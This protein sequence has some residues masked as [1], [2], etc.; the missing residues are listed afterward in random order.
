MN[1]NNRVVGLRLVRDVLCLFGLLFGAASQCL[2]V[3]SPIQIGSDPRIVAY[4]YDA[5]DIF[6]IQAR[7]MAVTHIQLNPDEEVLSFALG[8]TVQ[9]MTDQAGSNIFIKPI[10]A[11][12]STNAILT[13][14]KRTYQLFLQ[15]VPETGKWYQSVS[16]SY[17]DI[18]IKNK[19]QD[20][21]GLSRT[22]R[23]RDTSARALPVSDIGDLGFG[24]SSPL[25]R[26]ST[27]T[28]HVAIE[29]LNFDYDIEGTANFKPLQVFDDGRHTW[30]HM[31]RTAQE[32]PALFVVAE[33]GDIQLANFVVKGEYMVIQRLFPKALLKIGKQEV[34][35]INRKMKPNRTSCIFCNDN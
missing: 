14:S 10:R 18:L 29:N 6:P 33:D 15:S 5:K 2:A 22:S 24:G 17:P 8:D 34:S 30:L 4:S 27:V 12:L 3:P 9:W 1:S 28:P 7:P 31:P 11:G 32:A 25:S 23:P 20:I 19:V 13:T 21:T 26:S 35:V 16:W